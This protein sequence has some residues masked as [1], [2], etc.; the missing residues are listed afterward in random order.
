MEETVSSYT[1]ENQDKEIETFIEKLMKDKE[2][3]LENAINKL[4]VNQEN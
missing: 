3:E 1:V 4:T 2:E